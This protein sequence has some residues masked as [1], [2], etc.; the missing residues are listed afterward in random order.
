MLEGNGMTRPGPD[1]KH[2]GSGIVAPATRAE[3]QF[4]KALLTKWVW[5]KL[6]D[7]LRRG[8]SD[9]PIAAH[10]PGRSDEN[11]CGKGASP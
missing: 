4:P 6:C 5:F 10:G 9:L 8:L 7:C 2:C 3:S 1:L 11:V